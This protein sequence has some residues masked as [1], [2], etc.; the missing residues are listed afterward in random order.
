MRALV[1]AAVLAAAPNA[2]AEV[3]TMR[4]FDSTNLHMANHAGAMHWSEDITITVNLGAKGRAQVLSKGARGD[5]HMDVIGNATHNTD[6]KTTWTTAW[7]GG[8]KIVKGVLVLEL[9]LVKDSCEKVKEEQG[10]K[11]T[12]TC[13]AARQSAVMR[14]STET[15]EVGDKKTKV[16]AW[17]CATDDARDLGESP[18]SWLLGKK[19][20]IQVNAGRKMPMSYAP[21]PDG[22]TK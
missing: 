11:T 5:H 15:V 19:R 9:G 7:K 12:E 16:S 21:C 1:L 3:L 2:R 18:T 17:R 4:V 13:K 20:C 8:W 10:S 6:T 14:C 22:P